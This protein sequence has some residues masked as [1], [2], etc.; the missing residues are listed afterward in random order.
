MNRICTLP[1]FL[2]L[3]SSTAVLAAPTISVS[4]ATIYSS[5]TTLTLT[6]TVTATLPPTISGY[7]Q[8][9]CVSPGSSITIL[10]SYFGSQK[11][12]VLG[13]QGISV[14]LTIS[15]WNSSQITAMIPNNPGIAAGQWY[16]I[17]IQDTK[18]GTWLSNIDKNITICAAATMTTTL[19]PTVKT[20]IT[21][22]L[23]T[24]ISC[25][26]V[27]NIPHRYTHHAFNTCVTVHTRLTHYSTATRHTATGYSSARRYFKRQL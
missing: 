26:T 5:P 3:C 19:S 24:D 6:P 13:G 14:P 20:M 8:A 22:P 10:G 4:P 1:G 18:T 7:A 27:Q 12:A 2:L 17:G 15:S 11:A 16:Y 25:F 23:L 9:G 21:T